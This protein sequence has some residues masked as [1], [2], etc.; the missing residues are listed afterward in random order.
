VDLISG[1]KKS[2]AVSKEIT[3]RE[4]FRPP[5]ARIEDYFRSESG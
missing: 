5:T 4:C 2:L 3:T 1:H